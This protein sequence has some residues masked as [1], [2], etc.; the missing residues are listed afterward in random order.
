MPPSGKARRP[1]AVTEHFELVPLAGGVSSLRSLAN[2][3]TFHPVVGP[4]AEAEAVHVA[5][6][7]LVE[8]ANTLPTGHCLVIWD[9]GLGAAANALAAVRPLAAR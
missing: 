1:R 3:Q 6:S 4:T 8:R 7:R 5:G 9:V 2:G